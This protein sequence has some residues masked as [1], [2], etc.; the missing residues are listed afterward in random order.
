[1]TS[2]LGNTAKYAYTPVNVQVATVMKVNPLSIHT[3]TVSYCPHTGLYVVFRYTYY[4]GRTRT[5]LVG[6][7]F[8]NPLDATCAAVQAMPVGSELSYVE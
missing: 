7:D 1:M 6:S 3:A 4:Q 5:Q 2:T 8:T